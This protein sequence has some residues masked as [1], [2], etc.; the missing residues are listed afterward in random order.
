MTTIPRFG[1]VDLNGDGI[2][3]IVIKKL[4]ELKAILM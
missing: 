2:P 4:V 3:D 1:S